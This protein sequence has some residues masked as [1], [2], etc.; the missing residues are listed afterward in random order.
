MPAE[1]ARVHAQT[2]RAD[3]LPRLNRA[4]PRRPCR[5][6][7]D[8][9]P[10]ADVP[11]RPWSFRASQWTVAAEATTRRQAVEFTRQIR[12][13]SPATRILQLSVKTVETHRSNIMNKLQ[14]D[15]VAELVRAVRNRIVGD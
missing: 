5:A 1:A 14:L 8:S 12:T 10:D 4:G 9:P 3:S 13:S 7:P 15:S 2:L 11:H 6:G